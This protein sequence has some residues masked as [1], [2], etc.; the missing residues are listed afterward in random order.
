[1]AFANLFLDFISQFPLQVESKNCI[2]QDNLKV[3]ERCKEVCPHNAI[4]FENNRPKVDTSKCTVCGLCFSECPVRVFD[5]EID[6]EN[7]FDSKKNFLVGCY[8]SDHSQELDIKVPCLGLLNEEFLA[9]LALHKGGQVVLDTSKCESCPQKEVYKYIKNYIEKANLLIHYHKGEGAVKELQEDENIEELQAENEVSLLLEDE[10]KISKPHLSKKINVPLWRQIFFEKVK[11]LD[12][13]QVCYKP[14]E[15][16]NLRFATPVL[17]TQ[18]CQRSNVCSFWCLTKALSSNES[19]LYFTQILCT[20]CGLCEK[21]CP[22]SAIHLEKRF[23]PRWNIMGGKVLIGK[24]EKKTCKGCGKEF[25]G[26]PNEEYCLYCRK[27]KEMENL[28]YQ[29]LFKNS[30]KNKK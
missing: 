14:T 5:I 20:D 15:E 30:G 17:D 22:N 3:C 13:E 26:P 1:M 2:N 7:F 27:E 4:E 12:R 6:F 21:I 10:V 9:A 29:F 16:K 19:G 18:R 25:V 11:L 8:L 24:G 23:V 28:I